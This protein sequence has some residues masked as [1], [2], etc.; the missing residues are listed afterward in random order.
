MTSRTTDPSTSH[1]GAAHIAPKRMGLRAAF[2]QALEAIGPSTAN[3]I[4]RYAVQRGV[5]ANAESVRKRASELIRDGLIKLGPSRECSVTGQSAGTVE[6]TYDEVAIRNRSAVP[7]VQRRASSSN[8]G[9]RRTPE[10]P[11]ETVQGG[12]KHDSQHNQRQTLPT[13]EAER[14]EAVVQF[15]RSEREYRAIF[16]IATEMHHLAKLG[17]WPDGDSNDY[18]VAVES[19][20]AQGLIER[21]GSNVR[22]KRQEKQPTI[23]QQGLFDD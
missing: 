9:Q 23:K 20:A 14:I 15:M 6:L 12:V 13:P 1:L 16:A 22:F 10:R 5:A 7:D 18:I 11:G 4:A 17:T 8:S 21:H 19:A 3:E 2:I